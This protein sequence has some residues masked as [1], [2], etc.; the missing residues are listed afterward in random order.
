M[1]FMIEHAHLFDATTR[2][3]KDDWSVI[4]EGDRI[5]WRGPSREQPP[6]SRQR[7]DATGHTLLPGLID[8]HV[9]LSTDGGPDFF[10]QV[11]TDSVPRAVLRGARAAADFLKAG[12]TT[13]RDCGAANDVAIEVGKAIA[14]GIIDGPRVLA[15]GRVI[16]MTGGHGYFIGE[17]A[18]GPAQARAAARRQIK[19]G[20]SF[21]KAMSTGG[22]L[23]PGVTPGQTALL[24]DELTEIARE[25]HNAG[26]RVTTHAI[27][28]EGIKNALRAGYDSVE[29]SFYLDDE[30][31]EL[32]L[33]HDA[34]IVPT[35]VAVDRLVEHPA[36]LPSWVVDKAT[37]EI[38]F[39]KASFSA[40]VKAGARI[41]AGTDSGTPFN[42][43]GGLSSELDL[44]VGCGVSVID[45]ILS[46]TRWGAENI[47][48]EH[49]IGT[50]ETGKDADLLLVEGDPTSDLHDLQ[51]V[52]V[53]VA[54][55]K[56]VHSATS[57]SLG[58]WPTTDRS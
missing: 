58:A 3:S 30:A 39:H 4:V 33:K 11:L 25:A 35:L 23:S 16:T 46:A 10:G 19:A 53:V 6:F 34:I 15:A 8:S 49:R 18:D 28:T 44:M 20:A 5:A 40:A 47:D 13:V 55:G 14:G 32:F 56:I 50:I 52:R 41:A 24:S 36:E 9:H 31:I 22:V 26:R 1:T 29:H 17:E 43:H 27:G 51:N 7:L 2:E 48:L 12:I 54:R 38:E 37:E 57:S 42:T 21:L 45:A